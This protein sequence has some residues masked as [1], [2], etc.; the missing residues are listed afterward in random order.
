[1]KYI[2]LPLE[3]VV[4]YD[5]MGFAYLGCPVC[6]TH[7]M[8]T[9]LSGDNTMVIYCGEDNIQFRFNEKGLYE[10]DYCLYALNMFSYYENQKKDL[11][12][13][14]NKGLITYVMMLEGLHF[15]SQDLPEAS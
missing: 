12:I 15:A 3:K 2:V 8:R 11:K 9:Q 7:N 14:F 4:K 13:L 6:E 10:I 5:A 1:M